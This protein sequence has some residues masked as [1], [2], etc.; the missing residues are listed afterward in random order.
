VSALKR[1][2]FILIAGLWCTTASAARVLFFQA[3]PANPMVE[4]RL[5]LACRFY[6]IELVQGTNAVASDTPTAIVVDAGALRG[7]S[8]SDLPSEH[9]GVLIAGI[10]GQTD[11]KALGMW[12]LSAVQ[13]SQQVVQNLRGSF[14]SVAD[15]LPQLTAELAGQQLPVDIA[16]G[17]QLTA[18]SARPILSYADGHPLF[19]AAG[20]PQRPVFLLADLTVIDPPNSSVRFY[21]RGFFAEIAPYMIFLRNA[22]GESVWHADGDYANLTIDDPWL[23]ESY[24]NLNFAELLR[25][26]DQ[27]NF[28]TT[29]AYIPW[30]FDRPSSQAVL[31][32][33]KSRPDRYSLCVHG[34]NHDHREFYSYDEHPGAEWPARPLEEQDADLRQGLARIERFEHLSGLAVDRVMVFPHG[35]A[36]DQTLERMKQYNFMATSNVGYVPLDTPIPTDP[37]F[38]LRRVTD[39][40]GG[41]FA[42]LDRA[43]PGHLTPADIAIDL[44]L[45]NP[46]LF[47]EHLRYF[48]DSRAVFNP[49][50]QQVN[51]TQPAVQWVGLGT[52]SQ[53]LTLMRREDNGSWTVRAFSPD[54]LLSNPDR[55]PRQIRVIKKDDGNVPV[56]QVLVGENSVEWSRSSEGFIQIDVIVPPQQQRRVRVVYQ[57]NYSAAAEELAKSDRKVN[58]LRQLS[59]IR[60]QMLTAGPIGA[61]IDRFYYD[62]NLYQLGL[63]ALL[64]MG[65]G[66]V[67]G[68]FGIVF[69]IR[70]KRKHRHV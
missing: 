5:S 18:A 37:L 4:A 52:L 40:F 25:E 63:K 70:R 69:I 33:F 22:F 12:A 65:A 47:V 62:S 23:D 30:N 6:G 66:L 57:N 14:V 59:E 67:L 10:T 53:H 2:I 61:F 31:D 20:S 29:I 39:R 54:V 36:P 51:Q 43:E 26:M 68:L 16:E 46:V 60:D 15:D 44:F 42:S 21:D 17:S 13:P 9:R 27:A 49:V 56:E 64:A 11:T 28:H 3:D 55:A 7:L 34:N 50:A 45:D 58:L 41:G 1:T 8:S 38:W 24:G 32:L 19:V 35:I 48:S